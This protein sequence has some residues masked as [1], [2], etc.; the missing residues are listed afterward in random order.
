[1]KKQRIIIT[2]ICSLLLVACYTANEDDKLSKEPQ[3]ED[4]KMS[5]E[6]KKSVL[7]NS[8]DTE[9]L[10]SSL[11]DPNEDPELQ[12]EDIKTYFEYKKKLLE[13]SKKGIV[14]VTKEEFLN[15][16][17]GA[18]R[19]DALYKTNMGKRISIAYRE[20]KNNP[21]LYKNKDL[22]M[23]LKKDMEQLEILTRKE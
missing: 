19:E 3:I 6:H 1:M 16:N 12:K 5:I 23:E 21:E 14:T 15:D 8:L 2:S 4:L 20:A 17:A 22:F 13:D 9:K 11:I 7:I 18:F 10:F